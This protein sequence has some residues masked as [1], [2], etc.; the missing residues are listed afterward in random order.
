MTVLT[1]HFPIHKPI[2]ELHGCSHANRLKAV[3]STPVSKN[4]AGAD[5]VRVEILP[6]RLARG[7]PGTL[8]FSP[9]NTDGIEG[10][11]PPKA[12]QV[13]YLLR[14]VESR[15]GQGPTDDA[16]LGIAQDDDFRLNHDWSIRPEAQRF[17][18]LKIHFNAESGELLAQS[19]ALDRRSKFG[20][21]ATLGVVTRSGS[22]ETS[23]IVHLPH[24]TQDHLPK[25]RLIVT[26]KQRQELVPDSVARYIE[27]V[28]GGVFAKGDVLIRCI[29]AQFFLLN[30][31]ERTCELDLGIS[32]G[33]TLPVHPAKTFQA[34]TS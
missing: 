33:R 2:L 1:R 28:I 21:L 30:S 25:G 19:P 8:S 14:R 34:G 7:Q 23:R 4:H 6:Q 17:K 27:A 5:L 10:D 26:S 24:Q 20:K 9:P 18:T 13:H 15:I 16:P 3:S 31:E 11:C 29:L 12:I 32:G 22:D